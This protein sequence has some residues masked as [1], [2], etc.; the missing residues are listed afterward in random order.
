VVGR[1]QQPICETVKGAAAARVEGSMYAIT[2]GRAAVAPWP[3]AIPPQHL[4]ARREIAET[5]AA[6]FGAGVIVAQRNGAPALDRLQGSNGAC[7][8]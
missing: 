1:F 8:P 2:K 4:T 5:R 7:L 6:V 3:G